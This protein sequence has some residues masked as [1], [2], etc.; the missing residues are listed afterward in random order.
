V[1]RL[2]ASIEVAPADGDALR[3]LL[4][5]DFSVETS[6]VVDRLPPGW[7]NPRETE[8]H[9]LGRVRIVSYGTDEVMLDVDTEERAFLVLNDSY[10]PGWEAR[11][12]E[13]PAEIFRTNVFV[14]G[15][16]VASGHHRVEFRYR[17]ASFAQGVRL[18]VLGLLGLG[19][20]AVA[21]IRDQRRRENRRPGGAGNVQSR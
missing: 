19:G 21:G 4:A 17:P 7:S 20:L 10:F 13:K 12:D 9:S 18:S 1:A 16:P 2:V 11:V 8:P 5:P 6:A 15:L 3:R 14:R